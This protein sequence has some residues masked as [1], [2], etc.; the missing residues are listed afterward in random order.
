[1]TIGYLM[2]EYKKNPIGYEM[3]KRADGVLVRWE[4]LRLDGDNVY[5]KPVINLN[6]PKGQATVEDI[7]NGF[8]NAA[9]VG[10]IVAL[11]MSDDPALMLPGQT[12]PTVTKWF[13]RE[14]S[15]VDIPGNYNALVLY[16]ADEN[17]INLSDF[18]KQKLTPHNIM[19]IKFTPAQLLA[20]NL[21]ADAT[22][23]VVAKAFNDL[24][25]KAAKS[26]GLQTQLDNLSAS[27]VTDKV[28]VIL[29]DA[30]AAKKITKEISD[31]LKADYKSNPE[32]LKKLVDAMPAYVPLSK[33]IEDQTASDE[34]KKL[35]WD[36]L[37]DKGMLADLKADHFDLFKEK[38]KTEFGKEY[39][40]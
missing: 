34:V 19:E 6:H 23:V 14:C 31:N 4:D 3:H 36:E 30:L 1:M 39:A 20:M 11:D 25:A 5:A 7:E 15:L 17:P 18:K 28:T 32:G 27:V 26:E 29:S 22:E 24:V 21:S 40:E 37:S 12:G 33:K 38:F 10:H 16:D 2:D 9:S 8:L 13:N 35:S